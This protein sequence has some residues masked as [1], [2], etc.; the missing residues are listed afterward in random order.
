MSFI[1]C[2]GDTHEILDIVDY[3]VNLS[4]ELS[5]AYHIINHLKYD[6]LTNDT[7]GFIEDLEESKLYSLC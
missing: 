1:F 7:Q 4:P 5:K 6:L 3:L 2:D